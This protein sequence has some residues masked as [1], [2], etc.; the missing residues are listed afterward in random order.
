MKIGIEPY[1]TP[2]G[3]KIDQMNMP[4]VAM[5][6]RNGQID[7]SGNTRR[8][9]G[10]ASSTCVTSTSR[11]SVR[12]PT[13]TGWS[14]ALS[15]SGSRPPTVGGYGKLL[16]GG[17]DVVAHSS[18]LAS[19][20]FAGASAPTRSARTTSARNSRTAQAITAAPRLAVRFIVP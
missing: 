7:G 8:W 4:V 15:Q 12:R 13:T 5:A 3:V 16:A 14:G 9:S 20:G 17:G 11:T 1:V 2:Q 19:H 18:V 6:V 10:S